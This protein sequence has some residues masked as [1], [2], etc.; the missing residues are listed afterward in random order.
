MVSLYKFKPWHFIIIGVA[1]FMIFQMKLLPF[2]GAAYDL[3]DPATN[4][5]YTC[6]ST[7]DCY[8][9][10]TI[11]GTEAG[12]ALACTGGLCSF[13]ECIDGD[14][15]SISCPGGKSVT[16][17]EFNAGVWEPVSGAMC[18]AT[19]CSKN[20]DCI[21][22]A[23]T[24]CDKELETVTTTCDSTFKCT[25]PAGSRCSPTEEFFGQYKWYV[26]SGALVLI[27]I[28]GFIYSPQIRKMF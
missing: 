25:Q 1:I 11:T 22:S 19:E 23:D 16:V 13:A 6:E 20:S 27:G 17:R 21:M 14:D 2:L 7:L 15:E 3:T 5:T 28:V 18:P 24:D 4:T 10:I 8:T 12:P 26:I 9:H